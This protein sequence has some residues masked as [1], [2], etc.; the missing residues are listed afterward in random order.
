MT[1]VQIK[2]KG[3]SEMKAIVTKY[4]PS[5]RTKPARVR[6]SDGDGHSVTVVCDQLDSGP[7]QAAIALC[8]KMNWTG[9]LVKGWIR[10]GSWV[11]VFDDVH[12]TFAIPSPV[13]PTP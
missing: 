4:L 9:T 12:E 10:K 13:V 2:Q 3:V 11:F 5:T 6:A 8:H 1:F 7:K